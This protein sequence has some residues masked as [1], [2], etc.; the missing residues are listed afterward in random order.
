MTK[1][2]KDEAAS[3]LDKTPRA[4]ERYAAAG[5]LSVTYEKGKTRDVPMFD[6][7]EVEALAESLRQP[8]TPVRGVVATRGDNGDAG[9]SPLNCG[10]WRQ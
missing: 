6:R 9:V 5:R 2:T 7:A 3:L 8:S 10:A 4:V 1:I